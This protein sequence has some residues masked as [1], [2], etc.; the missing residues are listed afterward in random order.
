MHDYNYY[1]VPL[2]AEKSRFSKAYV[3]LYDAGRLGRMVINVA[4]LTQFDLKYEKEWFDVGHFWDAPST[5]LPFVTILSLD[6]APTG[7]QLVT[8]ECL[9]LRCSIYKY[10]VKLNNT[11]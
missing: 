5:L 10:Q 4:N 1:A 7:V 2:F 11:Q 3:P 8:M 9:V 6:P